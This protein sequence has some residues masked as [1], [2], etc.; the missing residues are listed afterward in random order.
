M[1]ENT[2]IEAF[3]LPLSDIVAITT[4]HPNFVTFGS[5]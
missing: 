5:Y 4:Q 2:I 3:A 1:E